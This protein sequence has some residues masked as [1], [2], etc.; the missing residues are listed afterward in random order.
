MRRSHLLWIYGVALL[1][2]SWSSL[3]EAGDIK[4]LCSQA[5]TEAMAELV[6][7]FEGQ[8]G[9]HVDIS[10][11]TTG[12]I[13]GRIEKG[14]PADVVVLATPALEPLTALDRLTEDRVELARSLVGVAVRPG[15]VTP[16]LTSADS[17]K[18][19]LLQAKSIA[20]PDPSSGG[21]SGIVFARALG[22][23]GIAQ[24][25]QAKS[26]LVPGGVGVGEL[27]ARGEA[28]V[29]VHMMSKL[30]PVRGV[31][32]VGPLP[33]S[34]QAP[35]VFAAGFGLLSFDPSAARA[36]IAFLTTPASADVLRAKGLEPLDPDPRSHRSNRPRT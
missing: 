23:L 11:G 27:V 17:L 29:A 14:E 20:Y 3:A 6:P 35:T 13:A 25:V 9:H 1:F 16:N 28:D 36:F 26:R 24:A 18:R 32:L 31:E 12:A 22:I 8:S 5:F 33:R 15:M 7:V 4:V 2:L 21:A 30:K 19:F 10:F 34:L